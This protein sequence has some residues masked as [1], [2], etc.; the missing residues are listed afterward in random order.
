LKRSRRN[1]L[2]E[3]R[4]SSDETVIAITEKGF[5]ENGRA[6]S[7]P[8]PNFR[9]EP[10]NIVEGRQVNRTCVIIPASTREDARQDHRISHASSARSM[11]SSMRV[12]LAVLG[13]WF[14]V[15]LSLRGKDIVA[16]EEHSLIDLKLGRKA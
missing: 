13:D 1:L 8:V 9:T 12:V 6:I 2:I 3:Q 5:S 4:I 16:K 11:D 14:I 15:S 7:N 10:E